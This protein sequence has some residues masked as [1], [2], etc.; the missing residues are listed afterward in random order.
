MNVV[1]P[2]ALTFRPRPVA[3]LISALL[4]WPLS[5]AADPAPD[6]LAEQGNPPTLQPRAAKRLTLLAVPRAPL[7]QTAVAD[8][9]V[10][11]LTAQFSD[12]QLWNP[13]TNRYDKVHLRSY[14]GTGI[15]PQAPYIAPMIETFPGQTVRVTLH[16]QLPKDATC[17]MGSGG[18]AN[19][20]HCFNGTNLHSHGLWINPAGNSDNVLVSINPGVDFQYEYNIPPDHP[21]G[22]FWYHPHK[23]GST[24]IQVSSG[25]AG[26]LIV[27]G[28]RTPTPE[29]TGDLDTLLKPIANQPFPE[30]VLVFQ[31]IQYACR[32]AQGKVKTNP[33]GTYRCD[34]DDQGTIDDYDQFGP[35]SWPASGRYTSINGR[36]IGDQLNAFEGA[37]AGVIERWR[38]VHAG[39]RD[40]VALQLRKRAPGAPPLA[41]LKA[42]DHASYISQHCTGE[43]LPLFRVAGDGLTT[44][45]A[46]QTDMLV[47]QPGYRWDAL[48]LFPEAGDYCL[49]DAA[50]SAGASVNQAPPSPQLL[51]MIPVADG[52]P[53]APVADG[54]P[55]APVDIPKVVS[56]Q[57]LAAAQAN[58]PEP[59][60]AKVLAELKDGLKLSSFIAHPDV[61][62]DQ[63]TGTQELTFNIDTSQSSEV[64]FQVDGNP[65]D[66]N[67]ID[68][69]LILGAVDEW[70]LKSTRASHP[71]HI[72]V[73]PFQVVKIIAPDG[74]TDVSAPGAVDNF[75]KDKQGNPIIDPQ[76]AGLKGVWKDTLFV[77]NIGGGVAGV[78]QVVIRTRYERYIGDFVLHCHILDHEDQGMMQNVRIALPDGNG[79]AA[80]GHH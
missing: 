77:K 66:A 43:P 20:P 27:R 58:M 9:V 22:T 73:N 1:P 41:N 15:D 78:Y 52:Q 45:A 74:K 64:F 68:R 67:R 21:A 34:P 42:G 59:V 11:D 44:A 46:V 30:R 7:G 13:G 14:Q 62:D 79:G 39:I 56:E 38:M 32:D 18:S 33:D 29:G 48:T 10:Y 50:A 63:V 57:L 75:E 3:L 12:G 71:Y 54:Q 76:Y 4:S 65:Y 70:T 25:M 72:H 55:V 80:H 51:G 26:A 36:V 61:T 40:S 69:T 35:G 6:P 16:N 24:A 31:Q 53:V 23:H 47:F 37:R 17:L 5:A 8:D 2:L 19:L 28:T 60:K 49:I